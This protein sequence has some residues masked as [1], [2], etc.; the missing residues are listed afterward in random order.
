MLLP[1]KASFPRNLRCARSYTPW[2]VTPLQTAKALRRRHELYLLRGN[3]EGALED[4][5]RCVS[6][7]ESVQDRTDTI[8]RKL[9]KAYYYTG[10][11]R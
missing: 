3:V 1:L 2:H 9:G 5:K 7:L 6:V 11:I 8:R 10:A 4:L